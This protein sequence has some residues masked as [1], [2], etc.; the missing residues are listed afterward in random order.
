M[1]LYY[2]ESVLPESYFDLETEP[3]MASK[4]YRLT[5][6]RKRIRGD[7][8][9]KS[10]LCQSIAKRL[11]TERGAYP[12]YGELYGAGSPEKTIE[13]AYGV[14][15]DDLWDLPATLIETEVE[16]R[17]KESL[18]QDDRI[19]SVKNFVFQRCENGLEVEFAVA[20]EEEETVIDWRLEYD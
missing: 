7:C 13:Y 2:F 9:G 17:I 20:T 19:L 8:D 18:L 1:T 4:T 6:N 15:F 3:I 14:A 10:S 12:I 5:E 11:S 16:A